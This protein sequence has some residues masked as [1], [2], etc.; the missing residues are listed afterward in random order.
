MKPTSVK[1]CR[2]GLDNGRDR[3]LRGAGVR[4]RRLVLQADSIGKS[5]VAGHRFIKVFFHRLIAFGL[6]G[7]FCISRQTH[8]RII[9]IQLD[10]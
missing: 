4:Q 8:S 3:Q 6:L 10:R 2:Y 5:T 9:V 7:T 1:L